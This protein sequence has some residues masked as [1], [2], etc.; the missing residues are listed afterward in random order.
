MT[1][2]PPPDRNRTGPE[3][4]HC[5]P[6]NS[7]NT[8][9]VECSTQHLDGRPLLS[10]GVHR[11]W[12]T[13]VLGTTCALCLGM[14]PAEGASPVS[15]S[16]PANG[17]LYVALDQLNYRVEPL[18]SSFRVS[19]VLAPI[20]GAGIVSYGITLK[21]DA[22][23]FDVG[24]PGIEIPAGLNFNG[25][26]GPGAFSD[27]GP[28][29]V[30]VKGTVDFLGDAIVRYD[31]PLVVS[32]I[33]APKNAVPGGATIL[34]LEPYLTAGPE[35]SLFV[36]GEGRVLDPDLV[37]RS[38]TVE[39]IPEP[40]T[41]PSWS[42]GAM[43]L[44]ARRRTQCC[45]PRT[46]H[47]SPGGAAHEH[48]APGLRPVSA[49]ES[50]APS[51]SLR[52]PRRSSGDCQ[53]MNPA[54]AF[55]NGLRLSIGCGMISISSLATK[56]LR[57][58]T[59]RSSQRRR[60]T[61]RACRGQHSGPLNDTAADPLHESS[62]SQRPKPATGPLP[63]QRPLSLRHDSVENTSPVFEIAA[64]G[65]KSIPSDRSSPVVG[66]VPPSQGS[67]VAEILVTTSA[68]GKCPAPELRRLRARS[69]PT[70]RANWLSN[71]QS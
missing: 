69:P 71:P 54:K 51:S 48:H 15:S 16:P 11:T 4:P 17:P 44:C 43:L 64:I 27:S 32:I 29:F 59:A 13:W 18:A 58:G 25:F 63:I 47:T 42:V 45:L 22:D 53:R 14:P 70:Q 2:L 30:S 19:V 39:F 1:V 20:P 21:F 7:G 65:Q 34:S 41:R 66:A 61:S 10:P 37:F 33:L 38:A 35:E 49:R 67:P 55:L 5:A 6:L 68:R 57:Q 3:R 50:R 8:E 12:T 24:R 40:S 28:G 62:A 60:A 52:R 36:D 26:A 46:Q 23:S 56:T 31:A 9:P